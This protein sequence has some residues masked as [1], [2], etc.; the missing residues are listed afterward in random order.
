[1]SSKPVVLVCVNEVSRSNG[2]RSSALDLAETIYRLGYDVYIGTNSVSG[3]ILLLKQNECPTIVPRSRILVLPAF[4]QRVER[5]TISSL[6]KTSAYSLL[7]LLRKDKRIYAILGSANVMIFACGQIPWRSIK[8]IR[9]MT[10]ARLVRNHAGSSLTFESVI[11][12]QSIPRPYP[13]SRARY[14]AYCEIFDGLLFQSGNQADECA[15]Y[16]RSLRDRCIVVKPSVQE[17]ALLAAKIESSP[18]DENRKAIINVG[19]IQPRKAQHLTLQAFR[20]IADRLSDSDLHFVGGVT[21]KN[22]FAGLE[23]LVRDGDMV[24]RVFF[25]GHRSDYLRFISH[26]SVVVQSSEQEGVSRVLREAMFLKVP[27]VGSSLSGTRELLAAD[28]E[29]LLVKSGDVLGLAEAI[30][31]VL[32]ER[33]LADNLASAAFDAYMRNNSYAVYERSVDAMIR[34]LLSSQPLAAQT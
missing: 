29:A 14:I 21:D 23:R 24:H 16:D 22:Y 15:S 19:G 26:A 28:K 31:R 6:L 4:F 17:S 30:E 3:A 2:G 1:M 27:I 18:F 12:N 11:D 34:N 13:S 32:T 33:S 10:S 8:K 5:K 9:E 20:R 25:H 7:S